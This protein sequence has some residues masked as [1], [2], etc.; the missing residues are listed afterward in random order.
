MHLLIPHASSVDEATQH[1]L[2]SLQLPHLS[3]LLGRLQATGQWGSDEHSLDSPHEIALAAW[4]GQDMPTTAAWAAAD[5]AHAWAWLTPVHVAVGSDGADL[6][7]PAVLALEDAERAALQALLSELW[8][9]AEGWQLRPAGDLGWLIGHEAQLEGLRAASL[10][11]VAGR[12]IEPWLPEARVLRRWQNEAQMLLHRHPVNTAREARGALVA[13]SVWISGIGRATGAAPEVT[14]DDRLIAPMTAGD[15]AAWRE[16][17]LALDAGPL[18]ALAEAAGRGEPVSLTLAGERL[19]RRFDTRPRSLT[20]RLR[21]W[22]SAGPAA[23]QIL[24]PL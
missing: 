20:E 8:P 6:L 13:N 21:G 24:E 9:A 5:T 1:L 23:S 10:T 11:R 16:A 2:H 15:L 4:R 7:P 18:R 3:A 22:F 17:W 12:A 19:A 14:L